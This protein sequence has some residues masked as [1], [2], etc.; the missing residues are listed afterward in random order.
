MA[1]SLRRV[2]R[3]AAPHAVSWRLWLLSAPFLILGLLFT[4]VSGD[5]SI[6]VAVR[7]LAVG[8]GGQLAMGL[9][10]A[11]AHWSVLRP[12]KRGSAGWL[13][14]LPTYA[15]AGAARGVSIGFL[16]DALLV[17][18][19]A[20]AVRVPTSIVL[21]GFS[22][23]LLASSAELWARYRH[24]RAELFHSLLSGEYS[25]A[26]QGVVL[27]TLRDLSLARIAD[28]I[29]SARRH[30]L[31]GLDAIRHSVTNGT[32]TTESVDEI[33]SR[34]DAHWRRA[35]HRAWLGASMDIPRITLGELL[36]TMASSKPLSLIVLVA[37]PAYGVAR[38]LESVPLESR[39]L[40]LGAW[41]IGSLMVG[42]LTNALAAR[43]GRGGVAVLLLGFVALQALPVVVG[44]QL[45]LAEELLL[46]MWFVGFVSAF[47]ASVLGFPPA[48]ERSGHVVLERLQERLDAT[49]LANLR[50]QSEMYVTAQKVAGYLHA[51]VRGNFLRLSMALRAAIEDGD[52]ERTLGIIE[53]L[54][55]L[56]GRIDVSE[57]EA[58]P[59]ETL[60]AFLANWGRVI[61]VSHQL[62]RVPVPEGLEPA[63]EAV[64]M[65]AVNNAV[66]HSGATS[67]DIVCAEEPE[68]FTL[69]I[70]SDGAT[71][72][73]GLSTGLGTA[74]L[75][76][77][78]PGRWQRRTTPHQLQE[79]R[80]CFPQETSRSLA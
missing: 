7:I 61:R 37:G 46:Q 5:W 34:S 36:R 3:L 65:E 4:E 50:S 30:T 57:P 18:E 72:A 59:L 27:G 58:T 24:Q 38:T 10:F 44:T 62:D 77:Y 66:R 17:G 41:L 45:S 12:A 15:L 69:R 11:L 70:T 51:Q 23:T 49:T 78:A 1:S 28:D 29:G 2:F 80:V 39:L 73:S 8:V 16:A 47:A 60:A 21:V 53:D 79:L 13:E 40:A 63:I 55:D 76:Q 48:L 19:R 56:V 14:V 25:R 52:R 9:V 74:I 64:V 33:F 31:L 42:A 22:L 32:I 6:D 54:R 75:N 43:A 35:S 68:G 20:L 67:V 26:R 71:V